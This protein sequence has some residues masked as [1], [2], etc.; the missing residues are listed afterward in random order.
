[1]TS[2]YFSGKITNSFFTF[3]NRY[4]LDTSRFFEMTPLE[5]DFI[6]DPYS[7]MDADQVE[8]LLKN[9]QRAY[10]QRFMDKD[11]VTTVGHNAPHLKSW[12]GLDSSL[13]FFNSPKA[14]YEKLD[15]FLGFFVSPPLS[16]YSKENNK[17]FF[18]FKTDFHKNKY[19]IV[20]D[21]LLAVFEILPVF[22]G[23]EQTEAE[24]KNETV[25]IY[26]MQEHTLALPLDLPKKASLKDRFQPH[27][28][29]DVKA[30]EIID[31]RGCPTLEVD[32]V[33]E[34]GLTSKGMVP[35][36]ASTGQFEA[37]ELRDGDP[38]YFFSKGLKKSC[39]N[40]RKLSPILKGRNIQ[41]QEDI[42]K[43]L[44]EKDASP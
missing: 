15:K 1:M 6:R 10:Q 22:L 21:Y 30:R 42:D 43:L 25:K 5:I 41:N 26:Y 31:S 9:I 13:D 29:A 28:I 37:R 4:E 39:Q 16:I 2:V 12:G 18:S 38:N 20:K 19:P 40:V 24:W 3:L 7:W 27:L 14:V 34:S 11:L 23:E 44:L 35:S 33:L 36:G 17:S 8:L 32:V